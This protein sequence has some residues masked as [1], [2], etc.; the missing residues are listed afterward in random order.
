VRKRGLQSVNASSDD[1]WVTTDEETSSNESEFEED[2]SNASEDGAL[3]GEDEIAWQDAVETLECY[4]EPQ[5]AAARS[6]E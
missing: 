5:R 6:L 3:E 2:C 1:E 4:A